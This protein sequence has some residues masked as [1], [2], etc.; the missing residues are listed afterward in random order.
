ANTSGK[1]K[2]QPSVEQRKRLLIAQGA[3]YRLGLSESKHMVA[4]NMR[5][6]LL[7]KSALHQLLPRRLGS[8]GGLLSL[9]TLKYVN[10]G[11]L[12][13]ALPLVLPL[14]TK[15]VNLLARPTTLIKPVLVGTTSVA[16]LLGAGFLLYRWRKVRQQKASA[17]F[18]TSRARS[19]F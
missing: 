18:R 8:L 9:R 5:V 11:S 16:G 3:M 17:G 14:L 13:L 4:S 2:S 6:D 12:K 15:G 1:T 10:F 19:W 7:A